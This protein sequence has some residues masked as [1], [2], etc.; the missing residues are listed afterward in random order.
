MHT[1]SKGPER[2]LEKLSILPNRGAEAGNAV[3]RVRRRYKLAAD[4]HWLR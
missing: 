2:N 1:N 3:F 4:Q